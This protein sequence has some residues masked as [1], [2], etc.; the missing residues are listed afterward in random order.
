MNEGQEEFIKNHFRKY[1]S[2]E[3]LSL[4]EDHE[5]VFGSYAYRGMVNVGKGWVPIVR[6]AVEELVALDN[7]SEP[8]EVVQVKEKF[9][10]LRIYTNIYSDEIQSII[11]KAEAE[12]D[13][14]C[15]HCGTQKDVQLRKTSWWK[16][17]CETCNDNRYSAENS[18]WNVHDVKEPD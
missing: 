13:K 3:L 15:E 6:K 14:V 12:C 18:K 2:P 7:L 8:L 9:G 16:T 10:G 5:E 4:I 1:A 11:R 17:L